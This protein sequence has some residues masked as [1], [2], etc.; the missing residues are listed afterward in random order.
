[1]KADLKSSSQTNVV[2]FL[3]NYEWIYIW[4]QVNL[5]AIAVSTDDVS[6]FIQ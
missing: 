4:I 6:I 3:T 1:M 2:P 5:S